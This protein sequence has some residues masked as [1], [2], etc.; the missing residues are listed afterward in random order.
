MATSPLGLSGILQAAL[1]TIDS[2]AATAFAQQPPYAAN[3][4]GNAPTAGFPVLIWENRRGRLISD[5][6]LAP[7]I[8]PTRVG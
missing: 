8:P 5:P 2:S 6:T 1:E 3:Y 7:P 4:I